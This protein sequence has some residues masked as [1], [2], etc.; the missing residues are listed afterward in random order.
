MSVSLHP[1]IP[2]PFSTQLLLIGAKCFISLC[3]VNILDGP[4]T[5]LCC[6]QDNVPAFPSSE[7]VAIIEHSLGGKLLDNYESFT[8]EPIAATNLGQVTHHVV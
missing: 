4:L 8:M 7:A 6:A 5:L 1:H 3:H 2:T